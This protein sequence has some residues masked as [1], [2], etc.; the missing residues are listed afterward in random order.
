MSRSIHQFSC[1]VSLF[2]ENAVASETAKVTEVVEVTSLYDLAQNITG[3]KPWSPGTYHNDHRKNEN[4][5]SISLL[6]LDVDD[7]CTLAEA[8]THFA[9]YKHIIA[10]TKSHQK[11]KNGI[12]CDRFRVILFL[13]E[14]VTT[15]SE[16]KKYWFAAGAKWPF[17]DQQCKDSARFFYPCLTI[18]SYADGFEFTEKQEPGV[19]LPK[20]S[21]KASG[22]KTKVKLSHATKDFLLEGAPPGQW[23]GAL[24]KA[25]MN[26]KQEGMELEE[27]INRLQSATLNYDGELDQKDLDTIE[28]VFHNRIPRH[29][30]QTAVY[31]DWPVLAK[32]MKG[33]DISGKPA[34]GA[35]ANWDHYF[36]KL[37]ITFTFNEFDANIYVN[38]EHFQDS[39]IDTFLIKM[40]DRGLSLG[41][42]ILCSYAHKVALENKFNPVKDAIEATKWDGKD[43]INELFQTLKTGPIEQEDA[44]AYEMYL[45]RWLIGVAAKLY[46][47]GQQNLV[48]TLQGDQGKGKSRWFE[49]FALWPQAFGEGAID[50][51]NKDHELRHL[52]HLIWH[53]PELDY[54]TGKRET[55]ALKD[56]LTKATV[57][58]RPAYGRTTRYGK[59]ICSFCASVNGTVFLVDPTGNRRFLV[60]PIQSVDHNHSVDMQQV[61]AQAK[62]AYDAGEKW[63]FEGEEVDQLIERNSRFEIQ[64]AISAAVKLAEPGEDPMTT[65]DLMVALGIENPKHAEI[66]RFGNC[67]KRRGVQKVRQRLAG[68]RDYVYMVKDPRKLSISRLSAVKKPESES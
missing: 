22:V 63:W 54:T 12:V 35:V 57:S 30:P 33:N 7:G 2:K 53:V 68:G 39:H 16:Y 38:G 42:D 59:S 51:G 32:D 37:G 31:F 3:S 26:M 1:Q 13:P 9:G 25:C 29:G 45:R 5:K 50:P 15:D 58:V 28:D 43:R 56:Y 11:D 6:T 49:K 46:S 55:G 65:L 27:M 20:R 23:H 67:M 34:S 18:K 48:L 8:K 14:T 19:K 64:D 47:P 60:I 41:K 24:V 66:I 17:I 61:L 4:L 40:K 36:S 21:T 62:A 10:T 44:V 52:T